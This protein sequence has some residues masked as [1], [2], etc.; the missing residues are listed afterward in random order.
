MYNPKSNKAEE[1]I[2]HEEVL[3]TLDF[4]QKN[5]NNVELKFNDSPWKLAEKALKDEFGADNVTNDMIYKYTLSILQ[6][7]NLILEPISASDPE[8]RRRQAIKKEDGSKLHPGDKLILPEI[9]DYINKK[10]MAYVA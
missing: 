7:N 1:F 4:A 10:Q 9:P 8:G 2:S 3:E 6:A 5:K